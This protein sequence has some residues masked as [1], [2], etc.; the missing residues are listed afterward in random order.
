MLPLDRWACPLIE[1]VDMQQATSVGVVIG[2]SLSE[3]H[4][5]KTFVGSSFYEYKR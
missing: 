4:T 5:S 2:A 1:I 3:P